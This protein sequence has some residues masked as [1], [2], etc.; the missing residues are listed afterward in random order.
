MFELNDDKR[1]CDHPLKAKT[2]EDHTSR[3]N[4]RK[5]QYYIR[6]ILQLRPI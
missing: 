2:R 5:Q 4:L 3:K 1:V 6:K